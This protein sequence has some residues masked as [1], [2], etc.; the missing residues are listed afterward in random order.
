LAELVRIGF[1]TVTRSA[2]LARGAERNEVK[3]FKIAEAGD[4][5][6]RSVRRV[7]LKRAK[8]TALRRSSAAEMLDALPEVRECSSARPRRIEEWGEVPML[9]GR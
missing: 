6:R 9:C 3:K 5:V 2:W 8:L 7:I 4:W 1:E